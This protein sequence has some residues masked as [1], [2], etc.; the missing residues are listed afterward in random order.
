MQQRLAKPSALRAAAAR[1]SLAG[2][3]WFPTLATKT[4][5][6]ARVGHPSVDIVW[7]FSYPTLT[8]KTK[9]RLGWGTQILKMEKVEG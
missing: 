8:A 2:D 4:R 1:Y 7:A 9:T 6:V 3:C 5:T